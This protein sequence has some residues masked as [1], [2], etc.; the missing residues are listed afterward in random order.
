MSI[1]CSSCAS[2]DSSGYETEGRPS[3]FWIRLGIS[4][5]L[6][7]QGMV[8]GLAINIASPTYGSATYWA[9][10]AALCASALIVMG[11]LGPRLIR[12]SWASLQA[13]KISVEGL[14]L[15][16]CMGALVGS[17]LS[18][19]TGTGSVYYEVVAIVLVVYSVGKRT[20]SLSR[21][22]VLR[23]VGQ[24]RETFDTAREILQSGE[25]R[26]TRMEFLSPGTLV[27]IDPGE[28]VSVDGVI[29]AGTGYLEQSQ[30]T[31]EPVPVIRRPGE[32]IRA[33]SWSVDGTF[34]VKTIE[35][36]GKRQID[37][38]LSWV[39]RARERPSRL[40]KWADET[41]QWFLPL[42]L[43]IAILTFFGW[44]LFGTAGWEMALFNSMAVLLVSCPCALGLA[45]P[46]AVWKGLFRLS[47]RGLLCRHGE[48]FDA[49]ARS[50]R[51]FFDKTGTLTASRLAVK[52]FT[53]NEGS[54]YS[55][56]VLRA[57]VA[58]IETGQE[59]PVARALADLS[60]TSEIRVAERRIL[61]GKGIQGIVHE[62]DSLI[63]IAIT[64]PDPS[65]SREVE[66]ANP[67]GLPGSLE[68]WVEHRKVAHIQIEES[69]REE[70]EECLEGLAA[71]KIAV[72]ILS[73]DPQSRWASIGGVTVQDRLLPGEKRER[74]QKSLALGEEPIFVGDGINDTPAMAA[75][76]ASVSIGEGASLSRAT[77]DAVLLGNHLST[78]LP[79]IDLARRIYRG[80][81]SNLRFAVLYNGV[82]IALA[83]SGV[84][85][86]V[87][88]ALLMLASS[89]T[90]SI[91]ALLSAEYPPSP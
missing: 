10:H 18:S 13:R 31:G 17:L 29:L 64:R 28:P 9:L 27:R 70:A 75:G 24:Y 51:I 59:H 86:P 84:L 33:G 78:L 22:K 3:L 53:V 87:V 12:E 14:F 2:L 5:V 57:W 6:A 52:K 74:V 44:L 20:G 19:A 25:E 81:E 90:V 21:A 30:L 69:L 66:E 65:A 43:T 77:A 91:R 35:P 8:F 80:V 83:A 16:T 42:V 41:I 34:T 48:A 56:A 40:Q 88:A 47:E 60:D 71:R 11:L 63:N 62:G 7:G 45:T 54:E 85:H 50:K 15:V 68:V 67:G 89:A 39:E 49:L 55:P 82:G 73:G 23:E 1:G 72:E 32:T 61:P 79:G 58:A 36:A 26:M 37:Q 38:I 76:A 46:I 4:L